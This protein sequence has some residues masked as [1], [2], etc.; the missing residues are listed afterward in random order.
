MSFYSYICV[1]PGVQGGAIFCNDFLQQSN[2]ADVQIGSSK[3]DS[4]SVSSCT[5]GAAC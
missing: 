4:Q 3:L 1:Y 2:T 5:V